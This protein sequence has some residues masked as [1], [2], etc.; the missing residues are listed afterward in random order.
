MAQL[1][2]LL[3]GINVAGANRLGMADLRTIAA[4]AGF[5][6]PVT[7]LQSGNLL[8]RTRRGPAS[9]ASVLRR[10]IHDATA[11]EIDVVIR[12][13]EQWRRIVDA[14]P[15]PDAAADDGTKVHVAFLQH[16][17]SDDVAALATESFDPEELTVVGGEVYLSLPD[18]I[19]R[20]KLAASL[21]RAARDNVS[22]VRNWN[23]V[24][25]I[26]GLLD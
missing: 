24:V 13:A 2:V 16:E 12:S 17:P 1:V 10:A 21:S 26:A 23:T 5:D 15:Y 8:V 25:A 9:A 4:D 7:Y 11:M 3:R 14:N 6:G 18:G 22:T 20:S 19:G